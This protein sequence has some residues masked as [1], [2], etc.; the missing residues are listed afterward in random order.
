M[1]CNWIA[2]PL[3]PPGTWNVVYENSNMHVMGGL[4][5]R[6]LVHWAINGLLQMQ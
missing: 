2:H 5:N 6:C 3:A 4:S 1:Q